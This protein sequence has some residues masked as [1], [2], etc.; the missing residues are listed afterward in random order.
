[1]RVRELVNPILTVSADLPVSKLAYMMDKRNTG[2][3]LIEEYGKPV[4]IITE[5]DIL[6]RVVAQ[7]KNP[8]VT[9]A[10][11]IM[12][13]TLYKIDHEA[14]V[15]DASSMMDENNIRRLLVTEQG[16]IIGKITVKAISRSFRYGLG[17]RLI[18]MDESAYY[19]PAYVLH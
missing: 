19:R 2:S 14:S 4:G 11:E 13:T 1:M 6:R 18:H 8:Y 7:G 9:S 3:A 16:R 17:Q 5:R 12:S 10:K 15:V